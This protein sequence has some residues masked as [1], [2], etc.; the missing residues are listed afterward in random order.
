MHSIVKNFC[1]RRPRFYGFII[2]TLAVVLGLLFDWFSQHFFA[3]GIHMLSLLG[4]T[5]LGVIG[6]FYFAF[7]HN[8]NRWFAKRSIQDRLSW[9]QVCLAVGLGLFIY[10]LAS[11]LDW[12]LSR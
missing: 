9:K 7:G 4:L 10:I 12:I 8:A 11:L 6:A 1:E 5:S 3:S 2:L